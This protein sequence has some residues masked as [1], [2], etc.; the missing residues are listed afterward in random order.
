MWHRIKRWLAYLFFGRQVVFMD[1]MGRGWCDKD[2]VIEEACRQLLLDYVEDEQELFR[3]EPLLLEFMNSEFCGEV[4]KEILIHQ[5]EAD[6]KTFELYKWF[7]YELPRLE[8]SIIEMNGQVS[9]LI[10][11]DMKERLRFETTTK[12]KEL[13]D[14][15]GTLWT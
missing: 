3:N 15:R 14:L 2:R 6:K 4:E 8:N 10:L 12:L 7:K 11:D 13:I 1:R 5:M 9:P